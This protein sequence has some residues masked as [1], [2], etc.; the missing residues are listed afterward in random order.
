MRERLELAYLRALGQ[1]DASHRWRNR[2]KKGRD[3]FRTRS[4]Q[5]FE[6]P[7]SPLQAQ[8]LFSRSVSM[9]EIE[10]SSYCNRTCWFCPNA[11][12]DRRSQKH[13]MDTALYGRI[14]A[15]LA[16]IGYRRKVSFSRYNEPLASRTILDRIGAAR[17]DIPA[18][19]LHLNT[20]GDYLD[21]DY[22]DALYGAGLRSLN[23]QIYLGND[24]Q[25]DHSRVRAKLLAQVTKLRL[26]HQITM[27]R[28][29]ERIEAKLSYRDMALRT[30][31]RNFA[32]SGCNRG[33]TVTLDES[34]T[35]TSPCASPFYH[36]YIDY[37]GSMVPCCNVR[38]D[39]PE[40][41]D[42]TLGKLSATTSIF[43]IYGSEAAA[44]WRR[45]L[46][47]YQHK[48]GVCTTC[49]F[50]TFPRTRRNERTQEQLVRLR[51]EGEAPSSPE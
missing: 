17:R 31:G 12:H 21:R 44:R 34:Y 48:T 10:T 35:R 2:L 50:V 46:V 29:G 19:L 41:A 3:P 15:D 43:D 4:P 1:L 40:H 13:H 14:L 6:G 36:A 51:D 5:H 16:R 39:I 11:I 22:L 24:E 30:Y 45:A 37:D 23:I 8:R 20:N 49:S 47:G 7:L 26:Q 9:V 27:D 28:P 25:Y 38:S 42:N 18:A 32:T 33:E